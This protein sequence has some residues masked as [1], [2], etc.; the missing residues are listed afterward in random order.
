V[1]R[2]LAFGLICLLVAGA[3]A[4][5]QARKAGAPASPDA[6]LHFIADT[7]RELGRLPFELTRL[8]DAE[9]MDLGNQM[10]AQAGAFGGSAASPEQS[11][12]AA[13][14]ERVGR[15]VAARAHRALPYRFHYTPNPGF[16]N[17]FALPGGHVYIYQGMLLLMDSEDQLVAVLGH[18][19]G[20]IDRF[21]CAERVQIEARTRRLPLGI[22][23][24]LA[25]I[26]IVIFQAGYS[27]NQELEADRV[28]LELAVRANYSPYGGIRLFEKFQQRERR[29]NAPPS[30]PQE[31]A[32]RVAAGTLGGYSRSHPYADER[33]VEMRHLI[34]QHGWENLMS[35]KPLAVW[36]ILHPAAQPAAAGQPGGATKPWSS[37][38]PKHSPPQRRSGHLLDLAC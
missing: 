8:S 38:F 11:E 30:S 27:K 7:Q 33:I 5:S 6:I 24:Q 22:I 37:G 36:S 12:V 25:Q 18:E 32:A 14:V 13:Y 4:L 35:E 9:E 2:W 3:L 15:Q 23:F 16:A 29:S 17:A 26:P 20:H 28:G 19:V 10:A 1:K 21:H 34:S 31:E